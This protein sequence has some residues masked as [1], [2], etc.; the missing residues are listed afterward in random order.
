ML[1]RHPQLEHAAGLH[2][3]RPRVGYTPGRARRHAAL[4]PG[5]GASM[6]PTDT[7][8][9][10]SGKKYPKRVPTVVTFVVLLVTGCLCF[11]L[12]HVFLAIPGVSGWFDSRAVEW[13][14]RGHSNVRRARE[15]AHL[16][17]P[18]LVCD[19]HPHARTLCFPPA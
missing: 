12:I 10:A 13:E 18:D 9:H 19:L 1:I 16:L 8:I 7:F 5:G 11:G 4:L 15:I 2:L 14:R 6:V 3:L 17:C